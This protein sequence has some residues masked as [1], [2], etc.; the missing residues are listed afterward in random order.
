[1]D[2]ERSKNLSRATNLAYFYLKFR[3][4]T[5]KEVKDYLSKKS[6]KFSYLSPEIIDQV[7]IDLEEEGVIDDKAF[8]IWF[9]DQRLRSKPKGEIALRQELSRMGIAKDLLD[10]YFQQN[11]IDQ[12]VEAGKAIARR[13]SLYSHLDKRKRFEKAANFLLRRGFS[14]DVIKKTI[15]EREEKE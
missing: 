9:I 4:R 14:F 10:D 2:Y 3:A 13:W 15:A 6:Q 8:V 12:E 1:M 5:K 11:P 7:L